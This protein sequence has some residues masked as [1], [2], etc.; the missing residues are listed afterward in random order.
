MRKA[1]GKKKKDALL[2]SLKMEEGSRDQAYRWPIEA[3]KAKN[4]GLLTL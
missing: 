2:P 3:G 1:F 4:T